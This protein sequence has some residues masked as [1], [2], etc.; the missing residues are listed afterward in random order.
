MSKYVLRS[1]G[2]SMAAVTAVFVCAVNGVLSESVARACLY[3]GMVLADILGFGAHDLGAY[4]FIF[5]GSVLFYSAFVLLLTWFVASRVA[6]T[7]S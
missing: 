2:I 3:P 4:V 1:V 7:Q 5:L 6:P